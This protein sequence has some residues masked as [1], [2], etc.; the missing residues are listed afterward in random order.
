MPPINNDSEA[1]RFYEAWETFIPLK[2]AGRIV[3]AFSATSVRV[4]F[5]VIFNYNPLNNDFPFR[6]ISRAI[7]RKRAGCHGAR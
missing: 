4:E 7:E 5:L 1:A 3:V 6:A 2:Q